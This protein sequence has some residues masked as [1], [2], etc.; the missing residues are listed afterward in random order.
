M[1]LIQQKVSHPDPSRS[2][3][4]ETEFWQALEPLIQEGKASLPPEKEGQ[5][6]SP[7]AAPA[8]KPQEEPSDMAQDM[9]LI[10]EF[11][12]RP[13][14]QPMNSSIYSYGPVDLFSRFRGQSSDP[15]SG[16]F[17][18]FALNGQSMGLSQKMSEFIKTPEEQALACDKEHRK[19]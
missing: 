16:P 9:E 3:T 15:G 19:D 8:N 12:P 11:L 6:E 1:R 13:A 17:R 4:E 5:A 18:P 2:P 10:N 14:G 7:Q